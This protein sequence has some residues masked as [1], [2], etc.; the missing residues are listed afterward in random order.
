MESFVRYAFIVIAVLFVTLYMNSRREKQREKRLSDPSITPENFTIR[1]DMGPVIVAMFWMVIALGVFLGAF[2]MVMGESAFFL[3]LGLFFVALGGFG[4][5]GQY[6]W[7]I[8]VNGNDISYRGYTGKVRNYRME[9]ISKVTVKDGSMG[10]GQKLTFWSGSSKMFVI[11]ENVDDVY[12][13]QRAM[14]AGVP[15][16]KK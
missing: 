4:L 5:M 13:L 10:S 9:E 15:V 14:D 12:L 8:D 6:V 2:L 1:Q 7:R 16:E 3:L 11:D